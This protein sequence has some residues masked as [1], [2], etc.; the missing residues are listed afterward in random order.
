MQFYYSTLCISYKFIYE[1]SSL[2]RY[3]EVPD[4]VK[5]RHRITLC[6]NSFKNWVNTMCA[7]EVVK[8]TMWTCPCPLE[9]L[10]CVGSQALSNTSHGCIEPPLLIYILNINSLPSA[11]MLSP[12]AL[13]LCFPVSVWFSEWAKLTK[14]HMFG[15]HNCKITNNPPCAHLV[16]G[17]G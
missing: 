7:N 15:L 9:F 11:M 14:W 8:P 4:I 16:P 3:W 1:M 10:C 17:S 6:V 2:S 13:M 5:S 12:S